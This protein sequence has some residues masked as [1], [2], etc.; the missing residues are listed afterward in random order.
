MKRPAIDVI[1]GPT[2]LSVAETVVKIDDFLKNEFQDTYF[3]KYY[4]NIY[5][6]TVEDTFDISD[7]TMDLQNERDLLRRIESDNG[8]RWSCDVNMGFAPGA[9]YPTVFHDPPDGGEV[10][11]LMTIDPL[12]T[13]FVEEL[14]AAHVPF[15]LFMTKT[16]R[17]IGANWFLAALEIDH[18]KRLPLEQI[19]NKSE[20]PRG[21]YAVGWKSGII[22]R[23]EVIDR[24]GV[25]DEEIY[26]STLGYEFFMSFPKP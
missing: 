15:V 26:R 6:D 7:E 11:F 9:V 4:A 22:T 20:W 25:K 18:W 3:S 14:E 1:F 24:L 8:G 19:F 5:Y 17:T 2:D 12:V 23:Q 21:T 16:A 13:R 10:T